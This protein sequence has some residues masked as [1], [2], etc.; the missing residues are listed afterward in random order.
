[1]AFMF[2]HLKLRPGKVQKFTELI[3]QVAPLLEKHGG[4]KLQ[5]SYFNVIGR[6]NTV[7]DVWE[8]PDANAVQSALESASQDPEFQKLVPAIEECVEDETLQLMT[9]LPV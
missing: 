2:A 4:W 6:L 7:V 8:I 3:G 9:K 5:G 1:M